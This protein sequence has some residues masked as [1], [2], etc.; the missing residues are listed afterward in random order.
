[1]CIPLYLPPKSPGSDSTVKT[2]ELEKRA[3]V[4]VSAVFVHT[5]SL[6]MTHFR[7][8]SFK[9]LSIAALALVGSSVLAD[10]GAIGGSNP[11]VNTLTGG[12]FGNAATIT[13]AT[14]INNLVV[15]TATL[16]SNSAT[17]WK[18]TVASGNSGKLIRTTVPAGCTTGCQILYTNVKLVK[19]SGTLGGG[20]TDPQA[21]KDITSGSTFFSTGLG[22][23]ASATSA[24]FDYLFDLKID[25][26]VNR[27]LLQGTFSDSLTV[28]LA[29]DA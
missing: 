19:T 22:A 8:F 5:E 18:L 10:T 29:S 27:D 20:L 16:D 4:V 15:Y 9:H 21:T 3:E 25:V 24:T 2:D 13:P 6:T 14:A 7:V 28:T 1:V 11:L 12:T 17:G 26:P 23:T